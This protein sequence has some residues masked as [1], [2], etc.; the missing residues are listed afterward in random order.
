[1]AM[2]III[3]WGSP[4][5]SYCSAD[6]TFDHVFAFIATNRYFYLCDHF[7]RWV[8]YLS[9]LPSPKVSPLSLFG[10]CQ[11]ASTC[12]LPRFPSLHLILLQKRDVGMPRF[13]LPKKENGPGCYTDHRPGSARHLS[14]IA[15]HP[16]SWC[17]H[18]GPCNDRQYYLYC[19]AMLD[20]WLRRW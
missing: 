7:L 19:K 18:L 17:D 8:F 15:N 13:P 5:I 12:A 14:S 2:L 1:M 3:V 16:N 9:P 4:R 10:H 20:W 6:A 11:K